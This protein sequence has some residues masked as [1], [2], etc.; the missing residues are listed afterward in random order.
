MA[1]IAIADMDPARM[2]SLSREYT[3]ATGMPLMLVDPEGRE[4][5]SMGACPLVAMLSGS[6]RRTALCRGHRRTAVQESLRWGEAYISVCPFGLITFA[7]PVFSA[8]HLTAGLVSGFS[9]L[10]QMKDDIRQDLR[11]RL[12]THGMRPRAGRWAKMRLRVV[13]SEALRESA[14]ELFESTAKAGMN[15]PR[16]L[17][18]SREKSAQQLTIAN[19]LSEIREGKED[20]V[21][22]LVAVQNEIIDKVVLGDLS[23]S[24]EIINRYLGLILL[25]CGMS[26]DMLKVRLLE[27]IVIISRAAIE[28]GISAEGLLGPRYSY[29][30]DLNASAGFDDLFWKVTKILE[31]F[32]TAVSQEMRRKG[33]A[34]VTQMKECVKKGFTTKLSTA[35]VAASAALSVS[36]AEHLFRKEVGMTISSWIA[37]QRIAYAK[38]LLERSDRTM[39][40]VAAECGFYDQSHFTKTFSTLEAATPLRYRMRARGENGATSETAA[41]P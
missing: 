24:R 26:F 12:R 29:L 17:R 23:G 8:G 15:D 14:T 34:H 11:R 39:A 33:W 18:E 19:F 22:S 25:E 37:H 6:P 38:Y 40:E 27:L 9:I 31:N 30:T 2:R 16:L 4:A 13:S 36:R 21:A 5:W 3:R 10:P 35:D 41:N 7:V 28:K 20:P 32:T 1:E